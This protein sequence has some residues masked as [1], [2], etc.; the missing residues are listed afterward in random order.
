MFNANSQWEY[1]IFLL[2][3][4]GDLEWSNGGQSHLNGVYVGGHSKSKTAA[5]SLFTSINII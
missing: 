2:L 4:L 1:N 3:P 5:I